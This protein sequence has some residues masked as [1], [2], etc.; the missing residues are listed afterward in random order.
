MRSS[1]QPLQ[2]KAEIA[3]IRAEEKSPKNLT[4]LREAEVSIIREKMNLIIAKKNMALPSTQAQLQ[5]LQLRM[6]KLLSWLALGGRA[7]PMVGSGRPV[8]VPNRVTANFRD[9]YLRSGKKTPIE[10]LLDVM[11]DEP[12]I[13]KAEENEGA[14]EHYVWTHK[15]RSIAA[16]IQV[17]PYIHP[18]LS[19]VEVGGHIGVSHEDALSELE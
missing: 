4:E 1:K 11:N 7:S 9:E 8:G 14:Y 13:K 19:S 5:R 15:D 18:K 17:A 3:A 6:D 16:A 2:T 10:F 12:R